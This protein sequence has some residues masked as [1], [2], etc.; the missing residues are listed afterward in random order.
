[1]KKGGTFLC[2]AG[3][4]EKDTLNLLPFVPRKTKM[5]NS[6]ETQSRLDKIAKRGTDALDEFYKRHGDWDGVPDKK[7]RKVKR[8]HN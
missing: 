6:N 3:S 2:L 4:S 7:K 8:D 5:K 1:M